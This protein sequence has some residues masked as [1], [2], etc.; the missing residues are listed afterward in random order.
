M[1]HLYLCCRTWWMTSSKS[2]GGALRRKRE[3]T[4]VTRLRQRHGESSLKMWVGPGVGIYY[5][6]RAFVYMIYIY[7]L[8]HSCFCFL[9]G[10][11]MLWLWS[12]IKFRESH[13]QTN[14]CVYASALSPKSWI[15]TNTRNIQPWHGALW[16]PVKTHQV[17]V[18]FWMMW[19][20][21]YWWE[22]QRGGKYGGEHRRTCAWIRE[23]DQIP[24]IFFSFTSPMARFTA[25]NIWALEDAF[26]VDFDLMTL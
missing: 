19:N 15:E 11:Y 12:T 8:Y 14:P 21:L 10:E 20:L 2:C 5:H 17:L 23:T 16:Y 18:L 25:T 4:R 24:L 1:H 6:S 9:L 26:P 3:V 7:I 22:L 13:L